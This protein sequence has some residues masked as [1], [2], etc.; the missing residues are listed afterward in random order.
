MEVFLKSIS[1]LFD[2]GEEDIVAVGKE[3]KSSRTS[4]LLLRRLLALSGSG[5]RYFLQNETMNRFSREERG[6]RTTRSII[7]RVNAS[8]RFSLQ[9]V[10]SGT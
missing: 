1:G 10:E 4:A 5:S 2:Y 9:T 6:V 7:S 3:R 8:M